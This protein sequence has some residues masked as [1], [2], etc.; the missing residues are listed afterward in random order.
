MRLERMRARDVGFKRVALVTRHQSWMVVMMSMMTMMMM[1][2]KHH[3]PL[4]DPTR[5]QQ[6]QF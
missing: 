2:R 3:A 1:N 4:E 6:Q 5:A